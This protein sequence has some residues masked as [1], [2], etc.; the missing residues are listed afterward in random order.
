M[1]DSVGIGCLIKET[2]FMLS[3]LV[4][5]L[6]RSSE[7]STSGFYSLKYLEWFGLPAAGYLALRQKSRKKEHF[8]EIVV[9]SI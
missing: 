9:N 3:L 1:R 7:I 6:Q 8:K 2:G 4:T 5:V